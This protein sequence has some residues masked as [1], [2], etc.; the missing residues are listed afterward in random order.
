MLQSRTNN[1]IRVY[2]KLQRIN[3]KAAQLL[4]TL[5]ITFLLAPH[6]ALPYLLVSLSKLTRVF[7]AL[8]LVC[9]VWSFFFK[10]T[11]NTHKQKL[12]G[13]RTSSVAHVVL[14]WKK[15]EMRQ[16]CLLSNLVPFANVWGVAQEQM[17]FWVVSVT[18]KVLCS[19]IS[20]VILSEHPCGH[21]W[22]KKRS[23]KGRGKSAFVSFETVERLGR[24][25][26]GELRKGFCR[27]EFS[28]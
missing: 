16:V 20:G 19:K 4:P 22:K 11:C 10:A 23:C 15:S 1:Y 5:T 18:C 25:F 13:V 21:K 17:R 7:F 28:A 9:C 6:A 26:W 2:L 27:G 12:Q 3:T 24:V 14:V 8:F